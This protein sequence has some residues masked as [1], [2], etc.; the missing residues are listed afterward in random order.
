MGI[1][2][3]GDYLS[4]QTVAQL[5]AHLF[6]DQFIAEATFSFKMELFFGVTLRS[7]TNLL[8]QAL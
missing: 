4:R 3:D 5:L 2:H 7:N 6:I 1:V 8:N